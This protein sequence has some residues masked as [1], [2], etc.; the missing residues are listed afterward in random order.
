MRKLSKK[1]E[2]EHVR[3]KIQTHFQR[4]T[5]KA[6]GGAGTVCASPVLCFSSACQHSALHGGTL[7]RRLN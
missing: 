2:W 4:Q 6:E 3:A 5:Q 7:K 1:M